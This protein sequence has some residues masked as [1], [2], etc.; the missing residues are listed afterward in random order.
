MHDQPIP[1]QQGLSRR[2]FLRAFLRVMAVLTAGAVITPSYAAL[3]EPFWIDVAQVRLKLRRL[4]QSFAGFRLAQISDLHFGNWM[5]PQYLQSALDLLA[6][7]APDAIA[8]TGDFVYGDV[9]T[10][11]AGLDSVR[12]ILASFAQRFP[13]FAI[14]GNH[15]HWTDVSLVRSFLDEVGIPELRNDIFPL[16]RGGQRLYLCGVDDIWEQ[17]ADLGPIRARLPE[18]ACAILM[19]HEPDFALQTAATGLFDLQISG[20]SHGGQIVIPFLGPPLLPFLGKI[21]HSGLYRVGEMFQ[22]TNRG[23]GMIRPTMR[24]NCRPEITIFTFE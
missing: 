7:Q 4:P 2:T 12:E 1:P 24:F 23:L 20:H 6:A 18:D 21:Y 3:L 8:I 5:T 16:E 19:A 13:V 11:R 10:A 9:P 17:H 15:D 22:Y 14:M